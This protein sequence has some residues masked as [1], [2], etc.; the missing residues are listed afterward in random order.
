MTSFRP[1]AVPFAL[2]SFAIIV[3]L[4]LAN[5][6]LFRL[7]LGTDYL[8]WYLQSGTVISLA[9]GFL[10]PVWGSVKARC[11]LISQHP[12]AYVGACL[13]LIGVFFVALSP[14]SRERK[15]RPSGA[16]AGVP[17]GLDAPFARS[18]DD[19]FYGL[20][21]FLMLLLCIGWALAVAPLAYFMNLVAGVPARQS[22]RGRLTDA[23][24]LEEGGQVK[25]LETDEE[26]DLYTSG[27]LPGQAANLSF[28]RD[29][30]AVTQAM[31][32]VILW[33]GNLA[34]ER[35]R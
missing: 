31:A 34:Y 1:R 21:A 5:R 4:V 25:L 35:L 13:Q 9:A 16:C 11:G 6:W 30:F 29:P 15:T 17:M 12:A 10:A 19:F 3:A 14:A 23:Y 2:I 8:L 18:L 24:L 33:L 20:L 7:V 26:I 27:K 32:A 28:A 22:L